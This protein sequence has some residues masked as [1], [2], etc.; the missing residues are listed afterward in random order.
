MSISTIVSRFGTFT[1]DSSDTTVNIYF[2]VPLFI[3]DL[4]GI[5]YIPAPIM[6][7]PGTATFVLAPDGVTYIP[8]PNPVLFSI[9]ELPSLILLEPTTND[10]LMTLYSSAVNIVNTKIKDLS[11]ESQ[12]KAFQSQLTTSQ[13]Q[14]TTSQAQL[15]V[16][17][18]QLTT[19]QAQLTTSESRL[20]VAKNPPSPQLTSYQR[21]ALVN[22][23][24]A[25]GQIESIT[26]EVA[27]P[28]AIPGLPMPPDIK[29]F[30]P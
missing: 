1:I 30:I 22:S 12:L 10:T 20:A 29:K 9:L 27:N 4:D 18:S 6:V 8:A 25:S 7:A 28:T 21:A 23:L 26:K 3:L 15:A 19:S 17:Q 16:S 5:T 13:A 11:D 14:L 24:K 2:Q